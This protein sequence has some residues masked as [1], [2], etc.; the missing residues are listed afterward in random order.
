MSYSWLHLNFQVGPTYHV[1]LLLDELVCPV[2]PSTGKSRWLDQR[3][4]N[5]ISVKLS[6]GV[7]GDADAWN[8]ITSLCRRKIAVQQQETTV[9]C[10]GKTFGGFGISGRGFHWFERIYMHFIRGTDSFRGLWMWKIPPKCVP[11]VVWCASICMFGL[12][13]SEMSSTAIRY[14]SITIH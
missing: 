13:V 9:V 6:R 1:Q 8:R 12:E 7:I 10:R 14:D 4:G 2:P 11:M 3:L 5:L